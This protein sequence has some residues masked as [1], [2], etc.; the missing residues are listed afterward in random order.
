MST[1]LFWLWGCR[2]SLE[3][4]YLEYMLVDCKSPIYDICFQIT[5]TELMVRDRSGFKEISSL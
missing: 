2:F 4:G 3:L 5:W 1:S